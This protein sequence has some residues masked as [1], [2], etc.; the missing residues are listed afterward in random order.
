VSGFSA[1]LLQ[2]VL[3]VGGDE[4]EEEGAPKPKKPKQERTPMEVMCSALDKPLFAPLAVASDDRAVVEAILGARCRLGPVRGLRPSLPVPLEAEDQQRQA[5]KAER[6]QRQAD[7]DWDWLENDLCMEL[8]KYD[9]ADGRVE[10][11]EDGSLRPAGGE[12]PQSF[13]PRASRSPRQRG[14][15]PWR[16]LALRAVKGARAQYR[17]ADSRR[18]VLKARGVTRRTNAD[19]KYERA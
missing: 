18:R 19:V 2:D 13:R 4:P 5:D 9:A 1:A 11:R 10:R 14:V 7:L 15:Q 8:A 17:L 16:K 6:E 12:A 3:A